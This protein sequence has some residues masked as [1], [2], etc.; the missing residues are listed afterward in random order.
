MMYIHINNET[1]KRIEQDTSRRRYS[2][3]ELKY[4]L[5]K[6]VKTARCK[7]T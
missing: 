5:T 2:Y 1:D 7:T 4:K 6:N 3:A